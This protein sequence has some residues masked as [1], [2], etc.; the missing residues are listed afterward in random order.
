MARLWASGFELNTATAGKEWSEGGS[1]GI[2]TDPVRS[3]TYAF[4]ADVNA[5]SGVVSVKQQY[6]ASEATSR[7]F[8]RFYFRVSVL[9]SA[10]HRIAAWNDSNS[11]I[12]S[13]SVYVTI[14][15]SGVL[16]LYD[17]DGQITG[18][19]NLS[20]DTWY[21]IEVLI[22]TTP[23]GAN[24]EIRA[25]VDGVEF[26]GSAVRGIS[27]TNLP[28]WFIIGGNLASEGHVATF[29][30][31]DVAINDSTGSF[32]NAWPG[33]GEIIHLR[34]NAAGDNEAWND[35]TGTTF[36]EVD[37]VTPDDN[38]THIEENT[39][40]AITDFNLDATPAALASDDT[41]NVVQVGV[42]FASEG[43]SS[44]N[45]TFALRIKASAGGT[46]EEGSTITPA[47]TTY[48]TNAP[49]APSNYNLTLYDLPGASTTAWTKADLDTAQIGVKLVA[50]SF[51]E[52]RVSTLWLLVDHKPAEAPA[53]YGDVF[54]SNRDLL[55]VG[56]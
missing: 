47:S 12:S 16:R 36:A 31:D 54:I 14:D 44:S 8:F 42:R 34:P 27:A 25:R 50:N 53:G 1:G 24:D 19:T 20:I 15:N 38:T 29:I 33:E 10:E 7:N 3:G 5:V 22:D 45:S 26:A 41:I 11:G 6:L 23:S 18:T 43:G 32:Q 37:E 9:P 39:A 28:F 52:A 55:G 13:P 48:S 4:K 49:A 56:V 21:R 40:N 2:V 51:W 17:E 35:G 30:F 46:V